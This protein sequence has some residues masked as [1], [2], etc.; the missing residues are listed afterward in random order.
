MLDRIGGYVRGQ[1]VS[2]F[3]VGALIAIALAL[4]GVRYSLLIGAMAAVFNIV[5]F[6]GASLA[7]VLAVLAALN[8]SADSGRADRWPSCRRRR[9]SRASSSP[10]T[11]W[12]APP[13]CI[14]WP[15]C[16]RC[17]PA[18]IWPAS[19]GA[20]V[21]VPLLAGALGDRPDAL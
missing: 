19:I 21:A 5:P 7:A 8:E 9:R 14:R 13:G 20:L 10:R 12:D 3:C 18:P 4:L 2:S 15:C 6:V 17:W 1:L 16:W 11:S